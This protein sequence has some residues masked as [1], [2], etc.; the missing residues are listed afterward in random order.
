[1]YFTVQNVNMPIG[2]KSKAGNLLLLAKESS[3]FAS[4][5]LALANFSL[6]PGI[7]AVEYVC[8]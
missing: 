2:D 4:A 3:I 5:L 8:R 7:G 6:P 1:M